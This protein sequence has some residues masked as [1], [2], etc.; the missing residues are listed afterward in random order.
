M[1]LSF[2]YNDLSLLRIPIF[3][4]PFTFTFT[5]FTEVLQIPLS[6]LGS[7]WRYVLL[8][9]ICPASDLDTQYRVFIPPTTAFRT[10]ELVI[11]SLWLQFNTTKY[12]TNPCAPK[13]LSKNEKTK[14]CEK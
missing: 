14:K 3:L 4:C 2:V 12:K 8:L 13:K 9:I 10:S 11:V 1:I 7:Y 5:A 6:K